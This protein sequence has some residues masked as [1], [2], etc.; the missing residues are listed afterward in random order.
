MG[1]D[2]TVEHVEDLTIP[3]DTL[4]RAQLIEIKLREFEFT[5]DG[6]KKTG[7]VFAWWF[8]VTQ[9]G[10]WKGRKVSG[11]T[12][13]RITDHPRNKLRQWAETLLGRELGEGVQLNTDDLL[14][15]PA[16]ISI[17]HEKDRKDPAKF[18]ERVDELLP[19]T[20]GFAVDDK[21]PF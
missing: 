1:Y 11:E 17:R 12:D 4:L 14:G 5:R 2:L 6:E 10:K 20:G 19:V 21:P 7:R 15:L 16:E 18:Y 3:E 9:E 8:E 13:A